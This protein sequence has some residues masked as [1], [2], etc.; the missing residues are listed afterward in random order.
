ME[1]VSKR[2]FAN[3]AIWRMAGTIAA[4][5]ISFA[6]SI[7]LARII[8][9]SDYGII[10]IA[11]VFIN[12]S[13]IFIE[14]GFTTALVRKKDVD[15]YDYSSVFFVSL[16]ISAV[17]YL[18]LFFCSPLLAGYYE[19]SILDSVL[20]VIGLMFF[21]Q[22]FSCTRNI[23]VQRQMK[24]KLLSICNIIG[25]VISGVAGVIAAYCGLGVWALVIQQLSQQ[26]IVTILLYCFVRIDIKWGFKW[27]RVKET[28]KFSAGVMGASLLNYGGS[29]LGNLFIGKIYSVE[30][31]GYYDKG[32]QLP[33]Q[34]SL[35]TFGSMSGVLLPTLASYQEDIENFKRVFRKV[36]RMTA[37]FIFPMMVGMAIVSQELIVVLLTEKWL[38]ALRIMQF[39]CLYYLATPFMLINI[40][41]FYSLGH[42][43]IRI[44]AELIRLVLI[45]GAIGIFAILLHCSISQLALINAIIAVI[46]AL[47]TYFEVRRLIK[48]GFKEVFFDFWKPALCSA[49]MGGVVFGIRYALP[50]IGLQSNIGI[51]IICVFG[52]I[53]VY[54]GLAFLFKDD[55]IKEFL[56]FLKNRKKKSQ[57]PAVENVDAVPSD[58][59]NDEPNNEEEQLESEKEEDTKNE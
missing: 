38:P 24:F 59:S 37:F 49:L 2:T 16:G 29:Y 3:S 50:L 44:R 30:D 58:V 31:L 22:A 48:Y 9:P 8:M 57:E 11:S 5:G 36:I 55:S 7:I 27:S 25:S 4:K 51:L 6:V 43:Y 33:M 47:E 21:I 12:L 18:I 39:S 32:G 35:Y 26:A 10:A 56:D 23:Y 40:S 19:E 41:V 15:G 42:K 17:L 54:F 53:I 34:A 14:G 52:G 1:Q 13:D 45:L 20:K 46:A 28:F